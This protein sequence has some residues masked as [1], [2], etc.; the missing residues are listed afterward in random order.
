MET[1]NTKFESETT[2]WS[3]KSSQESS[4][5]VGA[6]RPTSNGPGDD[7]ASAR[8]VSHRSPP[9][10]VDHMMVLVCDLP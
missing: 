5:H 9:A 3:L 1:R 7:V 8:R 6:L 10:D 4:I 2:A